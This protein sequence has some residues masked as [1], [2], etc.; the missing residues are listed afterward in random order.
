MCLVGFRSQGKRDEDEGAT[1][2]EAQ[3]ERKL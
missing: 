1:D 3:H 2:G